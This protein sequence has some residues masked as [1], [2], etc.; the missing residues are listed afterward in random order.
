MTTAENLNSLGQFSHF[1][2]ELIIGHSTK[3]IFNK[4]DM[5]LIEGEVCSYFYY[6]LSG[7]F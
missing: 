2:T 7:S 5:L 3:K 1:E 6:I 4:N